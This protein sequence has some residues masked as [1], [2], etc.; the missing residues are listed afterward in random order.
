MA[1]LSTLADAGLRISCPTEP[2]PCF[3]LKPGDPFKNHLSAEEKRI[4]NTQN[5][6]EDPFIFSLPPACVKESGW[7]KKNPNKQPNKKHVHPKAPLLSAIGMSVYMGL[8]YV[9]MSLK[10][11]WIKNFFYFFCWRIF[12]FP[13]ERLLWSTQTKNDVVRLFP[14]GSLAKFLPCVE[15]WI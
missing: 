3:L 14:L 6:L 10:S 4:C 7:I 12:C 5:Q 9:W 13:A 8:K 15:K 2:Q 11:T 1:C